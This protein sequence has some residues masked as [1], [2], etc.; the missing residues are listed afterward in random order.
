MELQLQRD[1]Q[2]WRR[3]IFDQQRSDLAKRLADRRLQ[4]SHLEEHIRRLE[5]EWKQLQ[6]QAAEF[7][8]ITNDRSDE[9]AAAQA[10]LERL[11]SVLEE[12]QRDFE[13]AKKEAANRPRTFAIVPYKG[14]RGTDRRP[15]YIE[16]TEQGIVLQPEGVVLNAEDFAGPLGPGNPLDAA[17]RTT[18]E[19][20]ARAGS[21]RTSWRTLPVAHCAS[22]RS[23]RVRGGSSG[24][25]VL[26][27]GVR[28]RTRGSG[29][30]SGISAPRF[31]VALGTPAD[32]RRCPSAADPVGGRHAESVSRR[33]ACGIRGHTDPRRVCTHGA[34]PVREI[35][36]EVVKNAAV[37]AARPA[38]GTRPEESREAGRSAL[39]HRIG[40]SRGFADG[41]SGGSGTQVQIAT[42]RCRHP[43]EANQLR[44][45]RP[46]AKTGGCRKRPL[47]RPG[48]LGPSA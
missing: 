8:S 16:C 27:R 13:K 17:L 9:Y 21:D 6:Q 30:G 3:D 11:K 44:L 45:P 4:L 35:E 33:V 34:P 18:R 43:M 5:R 47:M 15:I 32:R 12:S 38:K 1:D 48:S 28:L 46:A 26:G 37:L 7:D 36:K 39:V 22:Q 24:H 23:G 29:C 25:E 40:R 14:P 42:C 2:L 41:P 10:E 20:L 31:T 19:Y